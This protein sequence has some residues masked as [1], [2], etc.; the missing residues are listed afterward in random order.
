MHTCFE[1]F[2]KSDIWKVCNTVQRCRIEADR[3]CHS[4]AKHLIRC[5]MKHLTVTCIYCCS[6]SFV[7]LIFPE[8]RLK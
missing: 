7:T 3:V 4:G 2:Q 5:F 1:V 8:V 6:T